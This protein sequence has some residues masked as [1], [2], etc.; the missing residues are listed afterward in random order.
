MTNTIVLHLS[1]LHFGAKFNKK[2]WKQIRLK[3][4]RDVPDAVI[5]TGDVVNHPFFFS[6]NRARNELRDFQSSMS[7]AKGQDVPM[8]YVPGNHDTRV[9]G[10]IPL[11]T[12][13][14]LAAAALL[15]PFLMRDTSNLW[16]L[17]LS[18]FLPLLIMSTRLLFRRNLQRIFCDMLLSQ[19]RKFPDLNLGV[20]PLDSSITK[21]FGA[22]GAVN[23]DMVNDLTM[24]ID[25]ESDR[26]LFWIAAVHHHPLPIPSD[27]KWERSMLLKNAGTVLKNLIHQNVPLI[28]HGHKHH[29][30]F[31]RFFLATRKGQKEISVLSAGTPTHSN[32]P[33]YFHS[34]NVIAID[35]IGHAEVHVYEADKDV[36]FEVTGK[37]YVSSN[38]FYGNRKFLEH[39][40][41]KDLSAQQLVSTVTIDE[42][43]GALWGEEFTGLTSKVEVADFSYD[44]GFKCRAGHIFGASSSSRNGPKAKPV[45]SYVD[46]ETVVAKT[47]FRPHLQPS[48]KSFHFR[49]EYR[50]QNFCSLNSQQFADMYANDSRYK[51]NI[52]N[53]TFHVPD[54]IAIRELVLHVKFP[55]G[56]KLSD[57]FWLLR[58]VP[59]RPKTVAK[60]NQDGVTEPWIELGDT[61][62]V[63]VHAAASVF[64]RIVS[65]LPGAAYRISWTVPILDEQPSP[66]SV[67]MRKGLAQITNEWVTANEKDVRECLENLCAAAEDAFVRQASDVKKYTTTATVF[68]FDDNKKFLRNAFEIGDHQMLGEG[69]RYGLGLPGQAFKARRTV[70]YDKDIKIKYNPLVK[71]EESSKYKEHYDIEQEIE[72]SVAVPL[73]CV[74]DIV[75]DSAG[76]VSFK[77]QPYGVVNISFDGL[78]RDASVFDVSNNVSQAIFAAAVSRWVFQLLGSAILGINSGGKHD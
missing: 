61:E 27:H 22:H 33:D 5:V 34:Y 59:S 10:L 12:I 77:G 53:I 17:I 1:D 75:K 63:R 25:C 9:F 32:T 18:I 35:A 57:D 45:I 67:L 72:D 71:P 39:M 37:Y 8:L 69:F 31:A 73:F 40:E 15:V 2:K 21:S 19:A 60:S 42:F 51:E 48:N 65:P 4:E 58:R 11:Y 64:A 6:L 56:S 16:L 13:Y 66:Q 54:S 38:E 46:N 74:D 49:V 68:L 23:S 78:G 70:F 24:A 26:K 28:I 30:H 7:K 3:F 14:V 29:Q 36:A 52:E 47:Q 55:N 41:A 50:A 20:F 43:G 44:F 62:L 76:N